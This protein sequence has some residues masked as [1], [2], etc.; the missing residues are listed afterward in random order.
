MKNVSFSLI[1]P[2]AWRFILYSFWCIAVLFSQP[3]IASSASPG[4]VSPQ[5]S[6]GW[7][8]TVAVKSDGTVWAWGCN[9]HGQLGDGTDTDRN[10]PVQVKDI[11][12][13]LTIT[14]TSSFGGCELM[15]IMIYGNVLN[16]E[17]GVN[18]NIKVT[19]K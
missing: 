13:G 9:D 2:M 1:M 16:L 15:S 5:I 7:Y 6:A 19:K 3:L 14:K 18:Y 8:H 17:Q 11:N 4:L 12:L 10:T